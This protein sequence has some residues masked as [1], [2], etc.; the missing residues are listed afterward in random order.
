MNL[1]TV[2]LSSLAVLATA[3]APQR[4]HDDWLQYGTNG[5]S[6]IDAYNVAKLHA[7][8]RLELPAFADGSPLFVSRVDTSAGLR[9]LL[10]VETKEGQL[11]AL[12]AHNG[13]MIWNTTPPPGEQYT[14]STP[15]VDPQR[16]FVF[17]YALDGYI[18]KYA[19]ADGQELGGGGFP[20]LV[21]MKPDVEKG[22]SPLRIATARSGKTY[23]YMPTAGYPDPWPGDQGDYQGHLTAIDINSGD[24]RVFNAACSDKGFHLLATLDENDCASLQAGIWARAGA[25]YDPGTDRLFITIGNGAFNADRGGYDWGSSVVALRPDGSSDNG[26][27][28][29]SYTPVNFQEL[30]DADLD[31]SSTTI[32]VLP[33]AKRSTFGHLG[34]QIGKDGVLRLLNLADLSGQGGPRHLGGELQTLEVFGGHAILTRPLGWLDPAGRTWLFVTGYRG[35]LAFTLQR[36]AEGKPKLVEMWSRPQQGASPILVNGVLFYAST[37]NLMAVDALTGETLWSDHSIGNVHWQSPIVAG[38]E[39][40]M[41]DSDGRLT[42]YRLPVEWESNHPRPERRN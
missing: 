2:L 39:L 20:A 14:T 31:L 32:E 6:P 18:H 10:I 30:T 17:A 41:T 25:V 29:D 9:D 28:L 19:I 5:T 24:Q 1:R 26:E 22:S 13:E 15:A 37:N 7:V 38:S 23:I 4:P 8:W 3:A 35:A 36:D 27:P 42:A 33:V 12:D 11:L 40:F 34:V 21:T 16:K